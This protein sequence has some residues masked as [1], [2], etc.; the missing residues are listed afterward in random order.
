MN[1]QQTETN[2]ITNTKDNENQALKSTVTFMSG[3]VL[4]LGIGI[5]AIVKSSIGSIG[6]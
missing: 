4:G 1:K 6:K 5:Y 2:Q 3:L